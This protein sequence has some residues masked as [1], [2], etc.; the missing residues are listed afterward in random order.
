MPF[1]LH[2]LC[3][4]RRKQWH[5]RG[6]LVPSNTHISSSVHV[7]QHATHGVAL[8]LQW[9]NPQR[10]ATPQ[11][12]DMLTCIVKQLHAHK[13]APP[14]FCQAHALPGEVRGTSA[15]AAPKRR[16]ERLVPPAWSTQLT[17]I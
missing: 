7:I 1:V 11:G 8:L 5:S 2:A 16:R 4:W 6:P 13:S 12:Q 9:P 17:P 10:D 14:R 3:Q 15:Y